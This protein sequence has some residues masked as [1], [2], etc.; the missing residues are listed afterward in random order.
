[1]ASSSFL[2]PQYENLWLVSKHSYEQC[3]VNNSTDHQLILCDNP[4]NLKYHTVIFKRYSASADDPQFE[5]GKD[6]YFIGK[7]NVPSILKVKEGDEGVE[8][9]N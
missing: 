8:E 6:Y 7:E 2:D 1:M 4:F 3:Q 5:P 9:K